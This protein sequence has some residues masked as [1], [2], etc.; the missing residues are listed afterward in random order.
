MTT[1]RYILNRRPTGEPDREDFAIETV[2][3][4]SLD[5]G[6]V[7]VEVRYVSVDPYMRGRMRAGDSYAPAWAVGDPIPAGGVGTVTESRHPDW[8]VG[9]VVVGQL[10]WAE[11]TVVDG[12]TLSGVDPSVAALPAWLGVLGLTGR[13]A[14]FGMLDVADPRPGDTVV[15]SAAAGAVGS[16]AGQLASLAGATVI[17]I[18]GSD[19]KTTA[20]TDTFGFDDAINYRTTA[21]D[22]ALADRLEDGVDVYFDNVG[23]DITDAVF[24]HLA[25]GARVA[26]CGQIALYNEETV[27]TGPR[28]L[29]Q[30]IEHQASVEGFLVRQF[31]NRF[32]EATTRLSRWVEAG[33][34]H[35]EQ[36]V[37]DGFE[38]IPTAFA[39]LFE[40]TNIGK[41]VVDLAPEA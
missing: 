23:G 20:L 34:L 5:A 27:P 21:V 29:W 28:K 3:V 18:A 1:R 41:L 30:L 40:G 26:V 12:D 6:D 2:S 9:D 24:G 22:T 33:T 15:V 39:G 38:E 7:A 8:S 31:S 37:V 36:T 19:E 14:Y 10:A 13:T 32:E 25:T 17:G 35:H 16:I 4:P 11:H